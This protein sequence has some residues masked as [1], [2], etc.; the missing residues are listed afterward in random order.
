MSRSG[1]RGV[2][3]NSFRGG[4]SM[5]RHSHLGDNAM[6]HA[7]TV[8]V[9]ALSAAV[10]LVP[11]F[12]CGGDGG[13]GGGGAAVGLF[14]SENLP[15]VD[16]FLDDFSGEFP[17]N[18]WRIKEGAPAV[19]PDRGNPAPGLAMNATPI[20]SRVR[21]GF[22]FST[23]GP[24][25]V[26][27]DVGTPDFV[28]GQVGEFEVEMEDGNEEAEAEFEIRLGDGRIEFEIGD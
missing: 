11:T 27:F 12:G 17:G 5:S 1:G 18:N 21:A 20:E 4:V 13:G 24:L 16:S 7:M 10:A 23:A 6:K 26:S 14:A 28:S 3:G 8:R 22:I 2:Y 19:D 25:T 15:T 9:L